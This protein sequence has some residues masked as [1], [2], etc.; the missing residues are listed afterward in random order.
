MESARPILLSQP[1]KGGGQRYISSGLKGG[2][3]GAGHHT[4]PAS[5]SIDQ[6][7]SIDN[8]YGQSIFRRESSFIYGSSLKQTNSQCGIPHRQLICS[9]DKGHTVVTKHICCND[10]QCPVCYQKFTHRLADG[11]VER[12]LGYK[13]VYPEDPFYHLVL[14][15]LQ[16]TRYLNNKEAFA[17]VAKVFLKHGGK[18]AAMWYHPYRFK[19]GLI[20][21]LRKVQNQW[22]IENPKK[23]PPGFWKLAREDV[24][25]LGSFGEYLI[26]SPHF[27]ALAT[28]Y[29]L[30]SK[31]FHRVTGGW[32]YKKVK[33]DE[34]EDHVDKGEAVVESAFDLTG[35]DL[36]RVAHYLS[37]HCGYE[38]TKHSVRYVGEISYSKLGRRDKKTERMPAVCLK[39]G[40]PMIEYFVNQNTG[41][42]GDATGEEVMEKVI[43]WQ[44]YKRPKRVKD[45][46]RVIP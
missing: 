1:P 19:S 7:H 5:T 4:Y 38:W 8:I 42:L 43:T 33:R 39:C 27:H 17:A 22:M 26:Y 2:L 25:K 16:D 23:R 36:Q 40:A 9:K 29:L 44:Y 32:I 11:A 45:I 10:P 14:S 6:V 34:G 13:E 12:V 3:N 20:W 30:N 46:T 35:K 41:K 15:P 28:G 21:K 31:E 37:T 24:L 18:A